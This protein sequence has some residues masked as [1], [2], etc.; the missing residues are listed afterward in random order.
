MELWTRLLFWG[1]L[2][3]RSFSYYAP[4]KQLTFFFVDT[5]DT[6]VVLRRDYI[7]RDKSINL[8]Y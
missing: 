1:H 8:N 2:Y 6:V 7:E 4:N 5:W 3:E